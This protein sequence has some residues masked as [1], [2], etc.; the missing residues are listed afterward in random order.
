MHI[1]FTRLAEMR[2]Q[3]KANSFYGTF[4][5]ISLSSMIK[6]DLIKLVFEI[7]T[8]QNVFLLNHHMAAM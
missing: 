4:L 6:H 7:I 2:V 5:P 8:I 1:F 3:L